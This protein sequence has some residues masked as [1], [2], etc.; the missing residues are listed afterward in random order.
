MAIHKLL[1]RRGRWTRKHAPN[2]RL[3]HRPSIAL[4]TL[5]WWWCLLC[6]CVHRCHKCG[7][8]AERKWLCWPLFFL[9]SPIQTRLFAINFAK[10]DIWQSALH[11][12]DLFEHLLAI[13]MPYGF[14]RAHTHIKSTT[15]KAYALLV[16]ESYGVY[17]IVDLVARPL[18]K[19]HH[20]YRLI[21]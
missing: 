2:M 15:L 3:V 16:W 8:C 7:W 17:L 19:A 5:R 18:T 12:V 9:R 11:A 14:W 4:H 20:H 13:Q 10:V 6:W 21:V 1:L